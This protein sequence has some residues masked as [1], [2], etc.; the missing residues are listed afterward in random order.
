LIDTEAN[1][2]AHWSDINELGA[3]WGLKFLAFVYHI[4]GRRL[5]LFVMM[6]VIAFFF[7]FNPRARQSIH[8]FLDLV[9]EHEEITRPTFWSSFQNFIEFGA[10]ALDKLASWNND[11]K[12][13]KIQFPGKMKSLFELDPDKKGA[14]LFVSHLGNIEVLRALASHH[15]DRGLNVLVHTKHATKF[16]AIMKRINPSS[17]LK[18][19]EVSEI[20]PDVALMLKTKIEAGEWVAIAADR[21]PV[22]GRHNILKIPFLGKL[23]SFPIGPY[24]LAHLLERPVYMVSCIRDNDQ[25]RVEWEKL[26]DQIVMQRGRR[27][28][29]ATP[30]AN[31][32]AAWLEKLAIQNPHQW[33]N[34]F[35]FWR[36][37]EE[38]TK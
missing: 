4:A 35:D 23:A 38:V 28:E 14:V 33:Y 6:P 19:I 20:T 3:L 9:S 25:Y 17:Q 18:L 34:F 32:Y 21:P 16:N 31:K 13:E 27:P 29:S 10:S 1:K 22:I 26:A 24:V 11:I 2:S 5:C 15:K 7:L 30:W 8:K 37:D 12:P 36:S